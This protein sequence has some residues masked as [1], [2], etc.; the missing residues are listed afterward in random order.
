MEA[1]VELLLLSLFSYFLNF[2]YKLSDSSHPNLLNSI[3]ES[4][5]EFV[6]FIIKIDLFDLKNS[7]KY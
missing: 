5:F 4:Y 6:D 7:L 3:T 1:L 2:Y